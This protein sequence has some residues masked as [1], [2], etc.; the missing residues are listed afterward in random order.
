MVKYHLIGKSRERRQIPGNMQSS[1]LS[2]DNRK[3][4]KT[5]SYGE[6]WISNKTLHK[7]KSAGLNGFTAELH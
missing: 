1:K 4:K 6:D 7:K 3:T 5:N 2:Q